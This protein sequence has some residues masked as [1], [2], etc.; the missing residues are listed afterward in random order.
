MKKNFNAS[1][2]QYRSPPVVGDSFTPV[3]IARCDILWFEVCGTRPNT[4]SF[5]GF[6][7]IAKMAVESALKPTGT[8]TISIAGETI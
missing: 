5:F 8:G 2:E 4:I 7:E 3:T 6:M 1:S